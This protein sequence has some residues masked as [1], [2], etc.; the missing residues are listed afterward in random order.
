MNVDYK[1]VEEETWNFFHSRYGGT[2]IKRFYYKTYSFGADIEAKL[3]EFRV[4]ILPTLENWDKSKITNPKLIFTSKHELFSSLLVRLEQILNLEYPGLNLT[5][6]RMRPWKF[7]YNVDLDKVDNE[8]K[9]AIKE[10]MEVDGN[11]SSSQDTLDSKIEKN[12][13]VRFPGV[14]LEMMKKFDIDDIELSSN[15]TLVIEIASKDTN[16]FIFYHEKIDVLGY[17]KCEY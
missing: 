14:T 10:E 16:K 1:P 8:I 9:K 13:G 12:T 15:D 2:T 7:A 6:E 17:G 11:N 4:V 3:K 5:Q